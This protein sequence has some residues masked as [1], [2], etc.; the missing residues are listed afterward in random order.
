MP[1]AAAAPL[2]AATSATFEELGY[3]FVEACDAGPTGQR[4]DGIATVDFVGPFEGRLAVRLF[5]GVLAAISANMLGLDAP[6][7][8]DVQRDALGELA[9]VIC[10]NVLPLVAGVEPT[11]SLGTPRIAESWEDASRGA[12]KQVAAATLRVDDSGR[13]EVALFK[14]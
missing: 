4:E 1:D 13:A 12:G 7:P 5:G 10:G 14:R 2:Y 8:D 11:F 9:N 3:M 6:P